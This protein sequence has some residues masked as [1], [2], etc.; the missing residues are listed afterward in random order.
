MSVSVKNAVVCSII[1]SFLNFFPFRWSF[2]GKLYLLCFVFI[3]FGAKNPL[4]TSLF[5]EE[6]GRHFTCLKLHRGRIFIDCDSFLIRKSVFCD[7]QNILIYRYCVYVYVYLKTINLML[8]VVIHAATLQKKFLTRVSGLCDIFL[9][10][11]LLL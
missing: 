1:F 11:S 9:Q 5:M 7:S 2:F 6:M 3:I 4:S 8:S 10:W